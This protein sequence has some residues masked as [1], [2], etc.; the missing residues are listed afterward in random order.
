MAAKRALNLNDLLKAFKGREEN[1]YFGKEPGQVDFNYKGDPSQ[2]VKQPLASPSFMTK[3]FAPEY[4]AEINDINSD[5]ALQRKMVP[6]V[7]AER[8]QQ[9]SLDFQQQIDD[10]GKMVTPAVVAKLKQQLGRDPSQDEIDN[11]VTMAKAEHGTRL[12]A[13]F[14]VNAALSGEKFRSI[15]GPQIAAETDVAKM[16]ADKANMADDAE[17]RPGKRLLNKLLLTNATAGATKRHVLGLDAMEAENEAARIGQ[18]GKQ[19]AEYEADA[20]VREMQRSEYIKGADLR[21]KEKGFRTKQLAAT[22]PLIE[23]EAAARGRELADAKATSKFN[24][25]IRPQKEA[26]TKKLMEQ[27]WADAAYKLMNTATQYNAMNQGQQE[28][29][30]G[31]GNGGFGVKIG[32]LLP[33]FPAPTHTP[34]VT[35]NAPL[36]T[37]NAP[38]VTTNAPGAAVTPT[39]PAA[40]AKPLVATPNIEGA[41]DSMWS[42]PFTG[43]EFWKRLIRNLDP[44]YHAGN[45]SY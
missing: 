30:I 27:E 7:G 25:S 19:R 26:L 5:Y 36:V 21:E 44:A 15:G 23:A 31:V 34:L 24:S 41:E 20:P 6:I 38:L 11:A 18:E 29:V 16:Q 13:G 9:A 22:S 8:R 10:Y 43:I 4:A 40:G 1:P 14:D 35:T 45:R 12:N 33:L 37:T 39:T 42:Y 32:G 3:L 28:K 2:L 17:L